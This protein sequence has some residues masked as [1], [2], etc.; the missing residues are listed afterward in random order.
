MLVLG[1]KCNIN[2]PSGIVPSPSKD[3]LLSSSL[4]LDVRVGSLFS[5]VDIRV[6]LLFKPVCLLFKIVDATLG[7]L[8]KPLG[9]LFK[10]V[11]ATLGLLLKIVALEVVEGPCTQTQGSIVV[12]RSCPSLH[13][14]SCF[15]QM[16]FLKI[17]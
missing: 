6:G 2:L 16:V 10:T 15:L 11:D 4:V 8:F 5:L 7:L 17:Q 9:L 3:F 1:V 13:S 14:H 12:F